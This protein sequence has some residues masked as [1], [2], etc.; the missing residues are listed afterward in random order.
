MSQ[1]VVQRTDPIQDLSDPSI[2][3]REML[4]AFNM[5][6]QQF[7]DA[8]WLRAKQIIR[9][10]RQNHSRAGNFDMAGVNISD[11]CREEHV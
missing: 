9:I 4:Q 10:A 8:A 2:I 5:P 7:H 6:I 11:Q 3:D 1:E